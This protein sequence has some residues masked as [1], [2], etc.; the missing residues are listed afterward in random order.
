M[1]KKRILTVLQFL[2]FLGLGVFLVWWMARG[3]DDNGWLQIKAS[4]K[5]A[6]YWLF[7]PV[8][9]MLL[10]SH[11]IR[12]LRWKILMEPLGFKPSTFNVFNAVMIG[13]L[14]NLAFPRLGEVLK[15]TLLA[16]YE[17]V[18]PDKLIGTIVAERAIDL[19]CLVIAFVITILLQID[20]VGGY[21]VSLLEKIFTG[22]DH[23]ISWLK[24]SII[25]FIVFIIFWVMYQV[26]KRLSHIAFVEKIKNVLKGIWSGLNS[27][28]FIKSRRLFFVHTVLIWSLY[29]LSSRI[30]FYA[31][32]EV[33]DLGF[34]EA[35]SIMSFGSIGMIAT[36]GGLG[37]YQF[38]VQEILMLYGK[39]QL[40]GFTFGWI[41][42]IA[43]TAV[44]LF[45]G[46]ICFILMPLINRKKIDS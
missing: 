8:F 6:N 31:M 24:I 41:L 46:L 9:L 7:L 2:F 11:Y 43:Q 13:Y 44:I 25:L 28:R 21:A 27:V 29:L 14:A 42:W 12:A 45:G 20:I 10:L 35:F 16:R 37:A 5:Q 39:T 26:L 40:V 15:C 4:L 3:I 34:K 18:R 32:E 17:K 19:V 1:I 36:Q 33:S 30:G 23:K 22:D 38:I